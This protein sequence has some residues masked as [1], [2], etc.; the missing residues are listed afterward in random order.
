MDKPRRKMDWVGRFVRLRRKMTT[1]GGTILG[2][3]TIMRVEEN[4]AGL[5]LTKAETCAAC[6]CGHTYQIW[7]VSEADVELL[8]LS[9]E[10]HQQA[11]R[12]AS[13]HDIALAAMKF[14][15]EQAPLM[16]SG[17]SLSAFDQLEIAISDYRARFAESTP[18]A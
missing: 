17:S 13:L 8:P 9:A 10:L 6:R 14:Y 1:R 2:A 5:R 18:P 16:V 4:R 12:C 3:D 7:K 11:V 15:D